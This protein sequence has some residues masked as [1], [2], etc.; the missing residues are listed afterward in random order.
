MGGNYVRQKI[1]NT[2]IIRMKCC[3]IVQIKT[4]ILLKRSFNPGSVNP[5]LLVFTV[6]TVL[7]IK[8]FCMYKHFRL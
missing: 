8:G 1:I 6:P 7:N 3:N 2:F 4:F 5:V